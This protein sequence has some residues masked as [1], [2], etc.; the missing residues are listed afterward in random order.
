MC[1]VLSPHPHVYGNGLYSTWVEREEVRMCLGHCLI[2]SRT[3]WDVL[4]VVGRLQGIQSEQMHACFPFLCNVWH[5]TAWGRHFS[6]CLQKET[7]VFWGLSPTSL[8]W[9]GKRRWWRSLGFPRTGPDKI[10]AFKNAWEI[11]VWE[12]QKVNCAAESV[13]VVRQGPHSRSPW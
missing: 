5:K 9:R 1:I 11:S 6:I 12:S 10:S 3:C 7:A 4:D 13:F 2:S 8:K